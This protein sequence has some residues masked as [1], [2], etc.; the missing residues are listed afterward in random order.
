[1]LIFLNV[2]SFVIPALL[3]R[4]SMGP[5][6]FVTRAMHSLHESISATSTH[7]H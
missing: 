4:M 7:R 6:S 3:T 2:V 5:M 1:L